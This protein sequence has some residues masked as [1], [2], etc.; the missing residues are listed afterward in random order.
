MQIFLNETAIF[1]EN[2]CS[3]ESLLA[4]HNYTHS[5]FA[6]ML[7]QTFVPRAQYPII[8]LA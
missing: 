4:M 1:L 3:L 5:G 8:L 7:N 6:T 2:C